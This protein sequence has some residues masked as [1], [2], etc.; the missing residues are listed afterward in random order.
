[1]QIYRPHLKF[2]GSRTY[3]HGT[4]LY[5][6]I[7]NGASATGVGMPDGKLRIDL[8]RQLHRQADIVY[9]NADDTSEAPEDA[10]AGFSLSIGSE[11]VKGWV[12]PAGDAVTDRVSYDEGQILERAGIDDK[13]I[14][15]TDAPD[16]DPI[17]ITTC[18]AVKIH[19]TLSPPPEGQKWL[20]ARITL[21]RPFTDAVN[22]DVALDVTRFVGGRFSE[23]V[24]RS[25][26]EK[27]GSFN[28]LLG[29]VD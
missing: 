28:F 25:A 23:T 16:F 3:V 10:V 7:V 20:L 24:I 1:M 8:H 19:N 29:A 22:R 11:T 2:K 6:E 12:A 13:T 27:I 26:G 21:A 14:S 18:L 5:Q 15:L 17:E 9:L 4:T